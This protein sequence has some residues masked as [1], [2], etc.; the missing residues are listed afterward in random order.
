M[1]IALALLA[2]ETDI[3]AKPF[4]MPYSGEADDRG[5]NLKKPCL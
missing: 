4:Y 1:R 2:A 3:E 5:R